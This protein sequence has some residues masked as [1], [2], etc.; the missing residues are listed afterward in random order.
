M[1]AQRASVLACTPFE[2]NSLHEQDEKFLLQYTK[3]RIIYI[4]LLTSFLLEENV[5][6]LKKKTASVNQMKNYLRKEIRVPEVDMV[7]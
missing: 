7:C 6:N 4:E 5:D 1:K 3:V 2:E